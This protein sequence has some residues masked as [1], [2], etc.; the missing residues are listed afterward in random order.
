VLSI[1]VGDLPEQQLGSHADDLGPQTAPP[2]FM[3]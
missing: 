2:G 3:P 1:G